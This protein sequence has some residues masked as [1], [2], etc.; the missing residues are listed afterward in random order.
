MFMYAKSACAIPLES[1]VEISV[2]TDTMLV[3]TILSMVQTSPPFTYCL[4]VLAEE[5]LRETSSRAEG[6]RR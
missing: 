3:Y 2:Q 6:H 4:L 5:C 1:N